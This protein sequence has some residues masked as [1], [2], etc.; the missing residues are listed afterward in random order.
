[1]GV[2]E[3]LLGLVGEHES[4]TRCLAQIELAG[5]S[6]NELAEIIG[7]GEERVSVTFQETIRK[8]IIALSD[9]FP[10]YTHLLC[11][12]AA[13]EAGSVL[14]DNPSAKVVVT[15]AEYKKALQ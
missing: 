2:A 3:T 8:K 6:D 7:T 12:Y 15:D 5:M 9:A 4:L 13:E 10:S 14:Q 11:K 1:M